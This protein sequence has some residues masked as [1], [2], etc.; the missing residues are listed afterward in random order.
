MEHMIYSQQV[1]RSPSLWDKMLGKK[2]KSNAVIELNNLLA[3]KDLLDISLEEVQAISASYEVNFSTEFQDEIKGF[4][5]QYLHSCLDDKY[6][7]QE[8]LR[9]L[10]HLKYILGL[11]D[12]TVNQIHEELAGQ[13]YKNEVEKLLQDHRIDDRERA[14]IQQLQNDLK[15]PDE[16]AERIYSTS[17]RQLVEQFIH[18]AIEDKLLS[19]EEEQE[20]QSIAQNLNATIHLS[21]ANR[22][23]LEKYKLFWQIENGEMPEIDHQL[24]LPKKE[25][26]YFQSRIR[27]Y[28]EK[29]VGN[30]TIF[31]RA[32]LHLKI[33][34]GEYWRNI[35]QN[36]TFSPDADWEMV[37][38]G[39]LYLTNKRIMF[40]G[41]SEKRVLLLSRLFD[42][43]VYNNGLTLDKEQGHK[44]V[45]VEISHN[46][47]IFGMLLGKSI[48]ML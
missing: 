45:F 42:F 21:K 41:N 39:M 8:E 24:P 28:E 6:L 48:I 15:L 26:V 47:D 31:N 19:P 38:E 1:L 40:E 22:S 9:D 35:E 7:S 13:I 2:I 44:D 17:S 32:A 43:T 20:L 11:N 33:N 14:F 46:A 3:T 36:P 34:K 12:K 30:Q 25:K 16:I 27:W 37:D 18:D 29:N 23:A 10:R 4:Y 5:R